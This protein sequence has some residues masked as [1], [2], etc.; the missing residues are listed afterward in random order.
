[1]RVVILAAGCGSRLQKREPKALLPL[2]DGKL[3]LAHQIDNLSSY[4]NL[5]D[6]LVVVGY[7]QESIRSL[8]SDL[9]FVENPDYYRQNTAKSLLK[10]LMRFSGEDILWINGDVVFHPTILDLLLC[11][12][13]SSV[14][15]N[16][17]QVGEEE[18]KYRT[19][20]LQRVLEIG[21]KVDQPLGE[22]IGINFFKA[23][24]TKLLK[25]A[26]E[27]CSEE[28]YFEKGLQFCIEGGLDIRA[29][30]IP[31]TYS[32]EIDFPE[33]IERANR[34]IQLWKE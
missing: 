32:A 22:A 19:D 29:I 3:L 10:A 5:S 27:R 9:H 17:S 11:S 24:D 25:E 1:M 33:D 34:L 26:L 28:D 16:L 12:E 8:F 2:A 31:P 20:S 4:V 15:V 18:V 13:Q 23:A 14:I 6:I 30:K 21:K 7:R